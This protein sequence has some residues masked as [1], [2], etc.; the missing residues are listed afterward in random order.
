MIQQRV[1]GAVGE[2]YLDPAYVQVLSRFSPKRQARIQ[3]LLF[4]LHEEYDDGW[5]ELAGLV[6][7]WFESLCRYGDGTCGDCDW[8]DE[9]NRD[10]E[11]L[12]RSLGRRP[13]QRPRAPSHRPVNK[14]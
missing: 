3:K 7:L 12:Q 13:P 9:S 6:P 10:V 14:R 2:F 1:R 4:D 11:E 5:R 8:V